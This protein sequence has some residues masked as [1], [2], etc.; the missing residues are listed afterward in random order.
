MR[1]YKI[2]IGTAVAIAFSSTVSAAGLAVSET[3]TCKL[4]N[5]AK[6]VAI[7]EGKCRVTEKVHGNS[8]IYTIDMGGSEPFKFATAD[9][10]KT[11]LHGPEDVQFRDLGKGGIFKW[12]DFALVVAESA[13][14]Q[15]PSR[16]QPKVDF[17]DLRIGSDMHAERELENRGFVA[18][19]GSQSASGF[20]N[21]W[22]FNRKTGQCVQLE[23]A[24]GKVMTL[25]EVT[26]PKCR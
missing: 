25:N 14:R 20:S 19:H 3:A 7:Y 10:G 21:L 15:A 24:E 5:V 18:V 11:W 2:F 13:A 22:M 16:H 4:T 9:G 8:M 26:H 1:A 23:T 17:D 6:E 12:S